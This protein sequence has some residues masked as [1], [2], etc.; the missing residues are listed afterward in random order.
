M[1]LLIRLQAIWNIAV[2]IL[3]HTI[4]HFVL[5]KEDGLDKVVTE[6]TTLAS[7]AHGDQGMAR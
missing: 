5:Q 1:D 6:K 3:L 4:I 7:D 2:V